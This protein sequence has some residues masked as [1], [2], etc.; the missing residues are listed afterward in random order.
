MGVQARRTQHRARVKK[1]L[2]VRR[3]AGACPLEG[4]PLPEG[5]VLL[6]PSD[7]REGADARER[8]SRRAR[9]GA[10]LRDVLDGQGAARL[11]CWPSARTHQRTTHPSTMLSRINQT[12]CAAVVVLEGHIAERELLRS[13]VAFNAACRCAALVAAHTNNDDASANR[14]SDLRVNQR[15]G[16]RVHQPSARQPLPRFRRVLLEVGA[17]R[18]QAEGVA[19]CVHVGEHAR[20]GRRRGVASPSRACSTQ[21]A[22]SSSTESVASVCTCARRS[23]GSTIRCAASCSSECTGV[24]ARAYTVVPIMP[25]FGLAPVTAGD[26]CAVGDE[27]QAAGRSGRA[28]RR[29]R[30]W[31]CRRG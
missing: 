26:G 20:R 25:G 21:T 18:A 23:G 3:S 31:R 22:S 11:V 17:R 4:R 27:L 29:R 10:R 5:E 12:G 15:L 2:L 1:G 28:G 24:S 9:D 13:N 8:T 14:A 7:R 30:R 19:P 6:R 16:L